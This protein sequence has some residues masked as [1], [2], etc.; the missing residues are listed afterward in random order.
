MF[1]LCYEKRY[2]FF[3]PH[4]QNDSFCLKK[5]DTPLSI[6]HSTPQTLD[7]W[8]FIQSSLSTS[9][10]LQEWVKNHFANKLGYGI[11]AKH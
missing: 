5:L 1:N 7:C 8:F 6:T 9:I 3:H 2:G 4:L 11:I 10:L